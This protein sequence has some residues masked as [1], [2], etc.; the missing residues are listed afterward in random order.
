MY[1][2]SKRIGNFYPHDIRV[3]RFYGSEAISSETT[4]LFLER[5][6]LG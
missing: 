5:E 2:E 3:G 1:I 4:H 6:Y